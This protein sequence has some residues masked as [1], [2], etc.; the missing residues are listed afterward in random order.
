M[1]VTPLR[2]N[3]AIISNASP[4]QS[5]QARA[6]SRS[7]GRLAAWG[8]AMIEAIIGYEW[9]LSALDKL[10]SPV[11]RSG[12]VQ[13]LQQMST[14]AN[15]NGLWVT[16]VHQQVLPFAMGWATVVEGGE[17]LVAFGFF[18]GA[19]LWMSKGF[20]SAHWTIWLNV[21]VI[22]AVLG[23][24]M[25]TVSYYMMAG[26]TLPGLNLTAPFGEGLSLDGLLTGI[27]LGLFVVHVMALWIGDTPHVEA[28]WKDMAAT[29]HQDSGLN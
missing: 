24:V 25:M 1:S 28:Y 18:A 13:M 16:F 19:V 29:M 7:M 22:V 20:P 4:P 11:Y 5:L 8:L 2:R 14:S 27:G 26:N 15:P 17:L 12:F 10:F 23:G 9:L 6:A 21:G 3:I